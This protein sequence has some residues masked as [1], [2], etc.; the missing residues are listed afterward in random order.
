MIVFS[1]DIHHENAMQSQWHT[2]RAILLHWKSRT[3]GMVEAPG[4]EPVSE[5]RPPTGMGMITQ[6]QWWSA[7]AQVRDGLPG[8]ECFGQQ[9]LQ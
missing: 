7:Q 2:R 5:D 9:F 4:V 3:R 6:P 1:A 8:R